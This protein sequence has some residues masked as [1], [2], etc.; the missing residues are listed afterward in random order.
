MKYMTQLKLRYPERVTLLWG[1]RDL[2]KLSFVKDREEKMIGIKD[3]QY[4]KFLEEKLK[5]K[6]Y[7]HKT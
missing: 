3:T 6:H 7:E 1:N 4:R 2:N 5:N